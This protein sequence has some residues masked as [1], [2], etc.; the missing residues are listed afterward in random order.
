MK[1]DSRQL[2]LELVRTPSVSGDEDALAELVL[3]KLAEWSIDGQRIGGSLVA[4]MTRGTGPRLFFNSHLDT[5]PAGEGWNED[6]WDVDWKDG[7]LTG[8]GANDAK[9]SVAAMLH[10]LWRMRGTAFNGTVQVA[11]TACEE[12]TNAGMTEV[13]EALGQPDLA[14]TGE[15][16]GLEVVRTQAGL[17]VLKATWR[18]KACHAAHAVRVEHS[19]AMLTAARELAQLESAW[20]LEPQHPLIGSTTLVPTT[21]HA[22]ERRNVVPDL[23]VAHFDVRLAPPMTARDVSAQ[24]AERLPQAE[25]E[26]LS[27]RLPAVETD[28]DHPLVVAALAATGKPAAVGSPTLSDMAL[29]EGVPSVKCGPGQTVR[30]HTPNEYLEESE[31]TSACDAY[32]DLAHRIL[33]S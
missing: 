10:M 16:T 5:V 6:P 33:V 11:L 17:G 2:L 20:T 4:T 18:G 14:V 25:V 30:S 28:A 8:L 23:A 24:L 21:L 31:L 9:G 22:G 7:R 1:L 32:F 13:L 19:N 3:D 27:D 29:L 26:I 12:T 15:P